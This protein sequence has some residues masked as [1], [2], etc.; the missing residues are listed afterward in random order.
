MRAKFKLQSEAGF[1]LTEI[2]VTVAIFG[3]VLTAVYAAFTSQFNSWQTQEDVATVQADIRSAAEM[4]TR[5]IRNAGF[6]VP[7][8]SGVTTVAAAN[9]S[10]ITLNLAGSTSSTYVTTTNYTISG[11][12]PYTYVVP[13]N[14]TLGFQ[15]GQKYNA[16]DIRTK[17][18][19]MGNGV[20]D[21]ITA[22][23]TN[24]LTLTGTLNT[25]FVLNVGDLIVSPGYS[26]VTYSLA[27]PIFSRTDPVSGTVTLSN[28]IQSFALNYIMTDGTTTATPAS[29]SNIAAVNFT[30]NGNTSQ[31]ISKLSGQNRVRTV[32][33]I[34]ALRNY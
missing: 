20:N 28:N 11:G 18:V 29:M 31:K 24:T 7:T 21:Q 13:V 3:I 12:G 6:G 5:D 2:M 9:G 10:S 26:P 34:V 32:N 23:G 22:V 14:S 30:I 1:T 17:T 25:N 4:L 16:V 33:A 15:A 8:G 27:T 19:E